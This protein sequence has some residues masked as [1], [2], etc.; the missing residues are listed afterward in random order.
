MGDKFT[1]YVNVKL[2]VPSVYFSCFSLFTSEY[3]Q[4]TALNCSPVKGSFQ[5]IVSSGE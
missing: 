1:V 2:W 3:V 5:F 4:G